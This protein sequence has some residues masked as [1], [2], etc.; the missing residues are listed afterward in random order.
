MVTV[1][2]EE[3]VRQA[4]ENLL[5]GRVDKRVVSFTDYKNQ[6]SVL[7]PKVTVQIELTKGIVAQV[8]V[9]DYFT[10]ELK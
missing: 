2:L 4:I 5:N 6:Y 10:E 9:S 8:D 7:K 3:V 1:S